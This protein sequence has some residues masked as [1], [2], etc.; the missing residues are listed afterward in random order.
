MV[1]GLGSEYNITSDEDLWGPQGL[2]MYV[3]VSKPNEEWLL[4]SQFRLLFLLSEPF[5]PRLTFR[6]LPSWYILSWFSRT[7]GK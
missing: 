1:Y 6:H 7:S 2:L 4:N 5:L 3:A